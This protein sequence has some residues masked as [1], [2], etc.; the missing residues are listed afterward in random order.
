MS[1]G[2]RE[3]GRTPRFWEC[4][5]YFCGR[6][7]S[8]KA[9]LCQVWQQ[10]KKHNVGYGSRGKKHNVRCGGKRK[11]YNVR[12]CDRGKSI[13]SGAAAEENGIMLGVA[14]EDKSNM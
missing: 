7:D 5:P 10:K 4:L 1:E 8:R 3:W 13:M 2:S 12:C 11:C 9:A 14:T 6:G